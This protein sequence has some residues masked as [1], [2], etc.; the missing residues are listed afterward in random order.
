[1]PLMARRVNRLHGALRRLFG[2]GLG[3]LAVIFGNRFYFIDFLRFSGYERPTIG[4]DWSPGNMP[5]RPTEAT[6]PRPLLPGFAAM[7]GA[8]FPGKMQQTGLF[9]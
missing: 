5:A 6:F 4:L 1:M 8:G 2:G 9:P 7:V 3:S